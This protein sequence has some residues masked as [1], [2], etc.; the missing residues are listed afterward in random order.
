MVH[1]AS[2]ATS[3]E[4]TKPL[5]PKTDI[6]LRNEVAHSIQKGLQWLQKSQDPA[7]HWSQPDYPA[8]TA[9]ALTAFMGEPSE[10]YKTGK[11]E[12][13]T[14][15]FKYLMDKVKPDG[16]IYHQELPNYNTAVAMMAFRMAYNPDYD[17][18]LRNARNYLVGLQGDLGESG[19]LDDPFDGGI[20]YGKHPRSDLSNTVFA[21]EALYYT[22]HLLTDQEQQTL[23]MKDLNWEAA[24]SFIQH[25]QNLPSHNKLPWVSSDPQNRGGFVYSPEESKSGEDQL[26]DGKTALRSYGSMSYAGL[27]SYVYADL[28]KDDPRISAVVDW[29]QR[30]Y[31]IEENPGLGPQGLYYYYHTMAKALS[32]F[33]VQ[34]FKLADGT[35]INWRKDL[36]L[37]LLNL[38]NSEGFWVNDNGRWW[39]KD[40]TLVTAYTVMALEIVY[41]GL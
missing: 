8:L 7:G 35:E 24:V 30:N 23:G 5:L 25:C 10:T 28:P 29:L 32:L 14:K 34:T 1:C 41:R 22:K 40:P 37:K 4:S 13:I 27:L 31:S 26:P 15:G 9:L 20:G 39:E 2:E 19:K 18:I 16:G 12:F 38:Q 6:S 36:A 11:H 3:V 17:Q 21:L 33:G